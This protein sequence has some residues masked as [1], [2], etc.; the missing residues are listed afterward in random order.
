MARF[1][2][3]RRYHSDVLRGVANLEPHVRGIYNTILDLIYEAGGPI[4]VE[5]HDD[6][7]GL[8]AQNCCSVRKLKSAVEYLATLPKPKLHIAAGMISNPRAM[9]E[10]DR[11]DR[12]FTAQSEGGAEGGR[13]SGLVRKN[14]SKTSR[15]PREF[16]VNSKRKLGEFQA[17]PNEINGV[18][19]GHPEKESNP[20]C[21]CPLDSSSGDGEQPLRTPPSPPIGGG[22]RVA[23][24]SQADAKAERKAARTRALNALP[25]RV[26]P[27]NDDEAPT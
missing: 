9:V 27:A 25:S 12:L 24:K 5:T 23:S 1:P 8:A 4:S 10:L 14:T 16:H 6:W 3:H 20:P 7:K 22:A 21:P 17:G 19:E 13:R 15:I 18:R 26:K 11:A 2:Y